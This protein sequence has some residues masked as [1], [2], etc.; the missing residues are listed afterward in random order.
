VVLGVGH[1]HIL[2]LGSWF[3]MGPLWF[4]EGESLA[5]RNG[6]EVLGYLNMGCGGWLVPMASKEG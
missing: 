6:R 2:R 1:L 4:G 3:G 5:L